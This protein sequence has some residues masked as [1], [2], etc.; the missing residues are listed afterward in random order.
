MKKYQ[1]FTE[2]LINKHAEQYTGLDDEM[3]DACSDW[4]A[5]LS[6]YELID[7]A[8]THAQ[9]TSKIAMENAFE[10]FQQLQKEDVTK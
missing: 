8:D 2:F 7:Y 6:V 4:I 9:N 5:D 10:R 3:P 1:T